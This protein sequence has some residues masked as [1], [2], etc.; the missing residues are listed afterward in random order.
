MT[1]DKV[2]CQICKKWFKQLNGHLVKHGITSKEYRKIFPGSPLMSESLINDKIGKNNN[3]YGKKHTAKTNAKISTGNKG[4]IRSKETRK[5]ISDGLNTKN[6]FKNLFK[7]IDLYID[8]SIG[9]MVQCEICGEIM[10]QL[11]KH[12]VYKHNIN[13][14]EYKK[15]YPNALTIAPSISKIM[16]N[17]N[18]EKW[19]DDDYKKNIADQNRI[20]TIKQLAENPVFFDTKIELKMQDILTTHGYKYIM[21]KPCCNV[22]LPDI[23]FPNEKIAIFCDGDYWHNLP[24]Y[25]ERDR[26]QDKVL[27]KNGWI[28]L[29]FWEHEINDNIDDCL[30]RFEL[31]YWGCEMSNG[32]Q[33][34][35]SDYY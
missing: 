25:I 13:V 33:N 29:R 3:F 21:H 2:Q 34:K 14:E 16:I 32:K 17:K 4:K 8:L 12:L 5:K 28:P 9:K 24:N 11:S 15:L 6:R 27:L 10:Q 18:I 35:L 23:M 7:Q 30:Y 20:T 26:Y 19:Q 22:C 1:K 31:E